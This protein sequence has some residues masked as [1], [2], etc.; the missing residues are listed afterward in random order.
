MQD[1]DFNAER[2]RGFLQVFRF[3]L[4]VGVCWVEQDRN[5]GGRGHE[6]VQQGKSLCSEP[7]AELADAG[8]IPAR[9]TEA[10]NEAGLDRVVAGRRPPTRTSPTWYSGWKWAAPPGEE[11]GGLAD[12][13]GVAR[14]LR[15]GQHGATG[16]HGVA[17]GGPDRAAR[18]IA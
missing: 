7:S 11:R 9:T 13:L 5:C 16:A 1:E 18:R 10:G 8:E 4:A 2:G 14:C 12:L 3:V 6:F 17:P 15:A